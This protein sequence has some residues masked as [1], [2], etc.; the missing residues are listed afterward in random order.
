L[1]SPHPRPVAIHKDGNPQ[2]RFG[3]K[4]IE[5]RER[6]I[7][8]GTDSGS[9]ASLAQRNSSRDGGTRHA[10]GALWDGMSTPDFHPSSTK[11]NDMSATGGTLGPGAPIPSRWRP[12]L[13][14][15]SLKQSARSWL[16]RVLVRQQPTAYQR[17]LA[18]HIYYAGPPSALS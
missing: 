3:E 13:A 7:V 15:T 6:W 5:R 8:A 4:A 9:F 18:I 10:L 1:G 2:G 14:R 12:E 11:E 16:G 17:C